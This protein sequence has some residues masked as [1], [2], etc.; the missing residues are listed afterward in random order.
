M[1]CQVN[2]I[3]R[4]GMVVIVVFYIALWKM[5]ICVDIGDYLKYKADTSKYNIMEV[6]VEKKKSPTFAHHDVA[7]FY[8]NDKYGVEQEGRTYLNYNEHVGDYIEVAFDEHMAYVRPVI[9]ISVG[10]IF[11]Y[12][13]LI[14]VGIG[15]IYTFVKQ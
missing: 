2:I 13:I 4:I 1:D 9:T 14:F 7:I 6:R 12:A 10:G 5:I 8:Y 15:S 11:D 3:E